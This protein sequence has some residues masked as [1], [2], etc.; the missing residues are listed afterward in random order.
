M[1]LLGDFSINILTPII[2]YTKYGLGTQA[3][4]NTVHIYL[5]KT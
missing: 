5:G 4:Q 2:R 1:L 3:Y